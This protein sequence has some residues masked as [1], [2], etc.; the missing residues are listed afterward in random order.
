MRLRAS[1]DTPMPVTPVRP[2]VTGIDT[3]GYRQLTYNQKEF[4]LAG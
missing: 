3:Y 4:V 1:F 2:T